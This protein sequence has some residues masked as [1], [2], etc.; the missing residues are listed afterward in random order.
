MSRIKNPILFQGRN[1]H[2]QY[3]EGWYYKHVN[4]KKDVTLALI[5]GISNDPLD[6]HAFIQ[7]IYLSAKMLVPQTWYL[8]YDRSLFSYQ[9]HPFRIS[10]GSSH[11][12]QDKIELDI[13]EKDV[14]LYGFLEFEQ[15]TPLQTSFWSPS[16]M[17]PFA[18]L[19]FMECYH[20][21]IS[22]NH[23]I[24]GEVILNA[25]TISFDD[26]KG[27]MEKDWG[28]S[29]PKEYVWIQSNHFPQEDVSIMISVAHIPFLGMAFEGFIV[30][31]TI[32]SQEYRF[33]TYN[34]A[35]MTLVERIGKTMIK[36]RFSRKNL[37]L[38]VTASSDSSVD[39][40]APKQGKMNHAIK[41]GLNG[42]VVIK[43]TDKEQCI[44]EGTGIRAGIEIATLEKTE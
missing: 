6:A 10:I 29:F 37:I 3:F 21:V 34:Q 9:D 28:K 20:G 18:Y 24:K 35:K 11:F 40:K 2:K 7:I 22:M 23:K 38:E 1:K 25:K 8:R 43:L 26:G 42:K 39:L 17:G 30:N 33:A 32:G 16:I 36:Y 41:E 15:C 12:Y 13:F 5:P 31:L 27:Y 19:S 14:A 44:F 4:Q